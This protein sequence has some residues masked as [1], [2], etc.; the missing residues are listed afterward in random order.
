MFG[1][2]DNPCCF[3]FVLSAFLRKGVAFTV[4]A[5]HLRELLRQY[6]PTPW[7]HQAC[8]VKLSQIWSMTYGLGV[9]GACFSYPATPSL[10]AL[11]FFFRRHFIMR[12]EL[13]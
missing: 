9:P 13:I 12:N 2:R 5:A 1:V 4:Q 10:S 7:G 8:G 6:P 11:L 3:C